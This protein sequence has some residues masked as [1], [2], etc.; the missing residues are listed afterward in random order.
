MATQKYLPNYNENNSVATNLAL[1]L[2]KKHEKRILW[3][4]EDHRENTSLS[5]LQCCWKSP[6]LDCLQ[7]TTCLDAT[8]EAYLGHLT[9]LIVPS[10]FEVSEGRGI[11][12]FGN[13]WK[14]QC[15][16]F[17]IAYILTHLHL[18]SLSFLSFFCLPHPPTPPESLA[19]L[20]V[21]T[22]YV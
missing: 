5:L 10:C 14:T 9:L 11:C 19:L 6:C 7:L 20:L 12:F 2:H 3:D 18:S 16:H 8:Q 17:T 4:V 1:T 22:G 15:V 21:V 13:T